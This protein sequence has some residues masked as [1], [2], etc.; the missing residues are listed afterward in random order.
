MSII[1]FIIIL[2]ALILVHELGHFIAAKRAGVRVD[3]FGLGFPPRL[4]QKKIGET[5]YSINAFP[6]G[7]FVKIFGEDPNDESLMGVDSIRSLTHKK[8][9]VQ[10]WIISAGVVFNLLFAWLLI[11]S[12]FIVGLPY[13]VDD[14][15]YGARVQNP[16]LTITQ[17]LQ[18]SP[19]EEAGLKA[20]D[21]I[22]NIGFESDGITNPG[23]DATQE[24][25]SSHSE[26]SLTYIRGAETKTVALQSEEGIVDGR[27]AIGISM[28][29]I[30]ILKLPI[31]EAFFAGLSTTASMTYAM[32][33]GIFDFLK[34][35]FIGQA[36]F[37][38][39]AGP[40]GIVG[41]VSDAST[42]GF[43]HLISLTA[44]ISI[45]LAIIN[46]LPFPALDGGR[47][48]FLLI[49]TIKRSPIKPEVANIANG[50]GFI[51]LIAIMVAVT[52]HDIAKL[53]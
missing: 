14:T 20:G 26:I 53:I 50:I 24:F 30:G 51:V 44:V 35:I 2:A 22:A 34:N 23:I 46:L 10:A 36:D 37:Q 38:D 12:G 41:I 3:E 21:I 6:I 19:A 39:I 47:L 33:I 28:D 43:V 27:R 49:E 4:F 31:H 18:S 9:Y 52:F 11:S 17:V 40:V 45:N 42:L 7:G 32:A 5:V 1:L 13:S 29:V 15:K 25:I 8:R 16:S 48:F